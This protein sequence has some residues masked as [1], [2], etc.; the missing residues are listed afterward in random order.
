MKRGLR[1]GAWIWVF[2]SLAIFVYVLRPGNPSSGPTVERIVPPAIICLF[3]AL[4]GLV[5]LSLTVDRKR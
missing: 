5:V 1:I 4:P 3:L 2:L